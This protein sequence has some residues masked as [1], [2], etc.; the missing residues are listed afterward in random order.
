MR[1][2]V[3]DL[4]QDRADRES[5]LADLLASKSMMNVHLR[6]KRKDGSPVNTVLNLSVL[7]GVEG[8]HLIGTLVEDPERK[9]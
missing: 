5:M 1:T 6:M 9:A 2:A 7:P 3:W 4:Y 8:D